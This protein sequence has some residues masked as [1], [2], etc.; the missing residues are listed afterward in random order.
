MKTPIE[1]QQE[2]NGE[3]SVESIRDIQHDALI[4][5]TALIAR[6]MGTTDASKR[7]QQA[8]LEDFV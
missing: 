5:A 2:L 1:W 3:T 6:K 4:H 7:A 8:I